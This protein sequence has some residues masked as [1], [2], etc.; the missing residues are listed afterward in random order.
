[1]WNS[2]TTIDALYSFLTQPI[3][4]NIFIIAACN[5]HRGNSIIA[6]N[7]AVEASAD[8]DSWLKGTYYVRKLHPT[9]RFFMWDYGSLNEHQ[10]QEYVNAKMRML[11]HRMDDADVASLAELIVTSQI[12]M[13]EYA[14]HH[15][16]ERCIPDAKLC[17]TSSVSQRDIQRVFTFYQWLMKVYTTLENHKPPYHRRAVLVS[18]AVV[19][20]MR[21]NS[22]YRSDYRLFLDGQDRLPDEITFSQAFKDELEWCIDKVDLPPGIAK[23]TS[24]KENVFAMIVCTATRTPLII[25]GEPGCSK[26]LSFNVV[27]ANVKG[28]ESR[29]DTF[30]KT[31]LYHS[32][33]PHFY[34]CSRRTTSKEVERTFRVAVNRQRS[35]QKVP[36]PV[37]CVVFM[38]EAGLPEESRESLKV[39]HYYLDRQEV[40]FVGISNY[41][42]DAAKTNRAV[43][44]FR[45]KATT[46]SELD[47]LAKGC[48]IADGV[49]QASF[50]DSA[51]AFCEAYKNIREDQHFRGLFGLRDFVY[52]LNY[53]RH[54]HQGI[55]HPTLILQSLERNFNGTEAFKELCDIFFGKVCT[56]C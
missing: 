42:L 21:L 20:F 23:T 38:D 29:V 25:V 15:L 54:S 34:Q 27:V 30:R 46:S 9:L 24:L 3:P 18:L 2:T 19:Y 35:L 53:L 8:S 31:E 43:S 7:V 17:A 55:L 36:L 12:K 39:L 32:L 4:G 40:P 50:E 28:R 56:G 45:P 41:I 44:L 22:K 13:R 1:M 6:H 37:Y 33:D 52:F 49:A 16:T 47:E 5:P 48:L 51:A 14:E 10:E 26:T 11:N